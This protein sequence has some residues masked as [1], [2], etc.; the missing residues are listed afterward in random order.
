MKKIS[1]LFALLLLAF[2][3]VAQVDT[4]PFVEITGTSEIKITP[5]QIFI[6]ITLQE[7]TDK[8]KKSISEQEQDLIKALKSVGISEDKLTVIDANAHYGKSGFLS[9]EVISSKNLEL[10]V[11]DATE[12]KKAFEQLDKLNIKNAYLA[13]VDH[14]EMDK[15][16]KEAKI[17]AIKA[18]K[19]KAEYLLEAI[20]EELGGALIVRENNFNVY[21]NLGT[22]NA[23]YRSNAY[24]MS[25]DKGYNDVELDFKKITVTASVYVKWA[26]VE[27]K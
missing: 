19:E 18:A 15:Y 7:N 11:K 23:N 4:K 12:S 14:T 5:N 25:Q 26:I 9:K 13:R 1:T 21:R 17:K 3:T 2:S 8:S 16:K 6:R 27:K 10:E 24:E 22:V 20:G